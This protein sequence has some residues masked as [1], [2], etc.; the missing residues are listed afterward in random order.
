MKGIPLT[1]INST[2]FLDCYREKR[3]D[4]EGIAKATDNQQ[5]YVNWKVILERRRF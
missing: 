1:D 3:S 4:S 2:P 5:T